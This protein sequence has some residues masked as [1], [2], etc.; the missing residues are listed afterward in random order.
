MFSSIPCGLEALTSYGELEGLAAHPEDTPEAID[1][2]RLICYHW[3]PG[4][5]SPHDEAIGIVF[6]L[7]GKAIGTSCFPCL[8]F[9]CLGV[10]L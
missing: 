1:F 10:P 2:S 6:C 7:L 8:G 4:G 3:I 5:A 9:L